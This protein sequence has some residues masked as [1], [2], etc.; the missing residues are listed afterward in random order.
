MLMFNLQIRHGDKHKVEYLHRYR[1]IALPVLLLLH[2]RHCE[3]GRGYVDG[4]PVMVTTFH[5]IDNQDSYQVSSGF[6]VC[7][8]A[9]W[10][11]GWLIFWDEQSGAEQGSVR[12]PP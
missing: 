2:L 11:K 1:E 7:S 12:R 9:A 6:I 8:V 3:V 4:R 10:R 5:L